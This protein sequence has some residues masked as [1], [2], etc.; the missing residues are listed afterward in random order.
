MYVSPHV[1]RIIAYAE[2]ERDRQQGLAD[3]AK[4]KLY[5]AGA[6]PE[7][8]AHLLARVGHHLGAV[9]AWDDLIR[10][11]RAP[12]PLDETCWF[13]RRPKDHKWHLLAGRY[14]HEFVSGPL[15]STP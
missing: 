10:N 14:H 15:R 6:T 11:L 12:A 2:A 3:H 8:N 4:G 5:A 7:D 13:C 9:G 1:R